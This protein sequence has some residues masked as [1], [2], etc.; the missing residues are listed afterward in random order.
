ME[1]S[2]QHAGFFLQ[3][4]AENYHVVIVIT[5]HYILQ[6]PENFK[7]LA[8]FEELFYAHFLLATFLDSIQHEENG[9]SKVI[10]LGKK[11]PKDQKE[12]EKHL[13]LADLVVCV[14][15]DKRENEGLQAFFELLPTDS[16]LVSLEDQEGRNNSLKEFINCFND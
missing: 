2:Q 14:G 3:M 13:K 10:H 1:K 7:L 4:N 16:L 5:G 9:S 8:E 11:D 6:T 12:L 15:L